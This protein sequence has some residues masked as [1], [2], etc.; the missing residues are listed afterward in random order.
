MNKRH[1]DNQKMVKESTKKRELWMKPY[2][3]TK[4]D[5]GIVKKD[6]KHY[7]R[8]KFMD[9]KFEIEYVPPYVND[10]NGRI[11]GK[12]ILKLVNTCCVNKYL[13]KL[14]L[15]SNSTYFEIQQGLGKLTK[16][17]PYD[18]DECVLCTENFHLPHMKK[19]YCGECL[20]AVCIT[21]HYTEL[22][23]HK[24]KSTC[25]FCRK[26]TYYSIEKSFRE[27]NN[28]T[29]LNEFKNMIQLN[30]NDYYTPDVIEKIVKKIMNQI[31][32][33]LNM[34]MQEFLKK[35][36]QKIEAKLQQLTDILNIQIERANDQIN[37]SLTYYNSTT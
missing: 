8:S 28:Y 12:V 23:K 32:A 5:L 1:T 14:E 29:I 33:N 3:W 15:T 26:T 18:D 24:G 9:D 11:A 19:K 10:H 36:V 25:S 37:E 17:I 16:Y 31:F 30:L 22:F 21:C 34:T 6:L 2:K 20:N 4:R 7:L 13:Q 35:D 27:S